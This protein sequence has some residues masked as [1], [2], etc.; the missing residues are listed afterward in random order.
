MIA[1]GKV[2]KKY[3]ELLSE[4]RMSLEH[5][6]R[7]NYSISS[8]EPTQNQVGPTSMPV[9]ENDP[10]RVLV[11]NLHNLQKKGRI[12]LDSLSK[13][14]PLS[15]SKSGEL[16]LGS[17]TSATKLVSKLLRNGSEQTSSPGHCLSVGIN[18]WKR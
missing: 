12:F 16:V 15:M 6:K 3:N 4:F 11:S 13:V 8:Q 10:V 14:F 5:L 7:G 1:S 2:K 18:S 17:E 9:R